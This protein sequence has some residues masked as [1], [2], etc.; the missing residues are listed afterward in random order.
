MNTSAAPAFLSATKYRTHKGTTMLEFCVGLSLVT[1]TLSVTAYVA[2][3]WVRHRFDSQ[4]RVDT[5]NTEYALKR[6]DRDPVNVML[7]KG[8]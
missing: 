1:V 2:L 3:L 8:I 4:F 7:P 6:F 5:Y